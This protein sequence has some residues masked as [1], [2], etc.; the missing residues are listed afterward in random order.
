LACIKSKS[1]ESVSVLER[2]VLAGLFPEAVGLAAAPVAWHEA[3]A[4]PRQIIP[5]KANIF[6]S[7]NKKPPK[8]Y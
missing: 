7:F 8:V 2:A 1:G 4:P 3:K 5:A 6:L